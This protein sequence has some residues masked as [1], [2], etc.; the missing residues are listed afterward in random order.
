LSLELLLRAN[1]GELPI[2]PLWRRIAVRHRQSSPPESEI[3]LR[4]K[5][6][7]DKVWDRRDRILLD[8]DAAFM[9]GN[10]LS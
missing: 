1:T 6:A 3:Q 9:M 2:L 5:A 8:T 7:I 4:R 10:S